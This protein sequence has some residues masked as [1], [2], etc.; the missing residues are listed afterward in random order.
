MSLPGG[1]DDKCDLIT[2]GVREASGNVPTY[3][4]A[5]CRRRMNL[6]PISILYIA[7]LLLIAPALQAQ[8]PILRGIVLDDTGS[9]VKQAMVASVGAAALEDITDD[10]GH[11]SLRLNPTLRAGDRLRVRVEKSGF[12]AFDSKVVVASAP[13]FGFGESWHTR[14]FYERTAALYHNARGTPPKKLV[15][16]SLPRQRWR[17]D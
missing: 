17:I 14:G 13:K 11:F 15:W 8:A 5:R 3:A 2:K 7:V 4:R 16:A 9:P 10:F 12:Q 1:S 6:H